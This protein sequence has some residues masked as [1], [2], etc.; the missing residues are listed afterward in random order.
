[1]ASTTSKSTYAICPIED[2][3]VAFEADLDGDYL[4]PTCKIEML[5]TCPQCGDQIT[6]AEQVL[7]G[8]CEGNL[9]E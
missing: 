9:K 3:S 1:M 8:E 4:C 2:C 5:T 6:A 7:C